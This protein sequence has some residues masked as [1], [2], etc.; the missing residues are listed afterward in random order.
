MKTILSKI[1]QSSLIKEFLLLPER[2]IF[3]TNCALDIALRLYFLSVTKKKKILFVSSNIPKIQEIVSDINLIQ[4][5]FAQFL[6][7][8]DFLPYE[9]RSSSL[10]VLEQRIVVLDRFYSNKSGVYCLSPSSALRNLPKKQKLSSLCAK[11][12]EEISQEALSEKL[13]GLGYGKSYQVYDGG[14]F[15]IRG[16]IFDICIPGEQLGVR[17]EYEYDTISKIRYF[18]LQT[19]LTTAELKQIKILPAREF[20]LFEATPK[21]EKIGEKVKEFGYYQ[22]IENDLAEIF[23]VEAMVEK[24]NVLVFLDDLNLLSAQ[25][26]LAEEA[27]VAM[28][29]VDRPLV[30]SQDIFIKER[31]LNTIL[32]SVYTFS[33][34]YDS[35]KEFL[36]S[37]MQV[38][39]N[40]QGNMEL[41]QVEIKKFFDAGNSIVLQADNKAQIKRI[42]KILKDDYEISYDLGVFSTGFI[43]DDVKLSVFTD[44]QIFNRYISKQN[45]FKGNPTIKKAETLQ[46][47][48]YLVHSDYGIGIYGGLQTNVVDGKTIEC[49]VLYYQG[50]DAIYLPS[51]SLDKVS[52][53]VAAEGIEVKQDKI[54]SKRWQ[55]TKRKVKE[56]IKVVAKDLVDFYA[57]RSQEKGISFLPDN[58][59]QESMENEFLYEPTRDQFEA[60]SQ[61][62]EDMESEK[63]ME[64]LLCG[65]VGYGKT[66]VAVRAAFKAVSSSYQVAVL[67]PTTLLC[68]QLFTVFSQRLA[69]Y[70]VRIKMLSRF[71]KKS[72]QKRTVAELAEGTVDIVIGTHRLLSS[73]IDFARLGLLVI[74]EEH[75]FGVR[76]KEKLRKLKSNIDTLYMSATP[77]PR[78]LNMALSGVKDIS[79]ILSG[80]KYRLPVKTVVSYYQKNLLKHVIQKEVNR[81]GQ[82]FFVHNR[83]E[84]IGEELEKLQKLL[85]NVSMKIAHG[86]MKETELEEI[87]LDFYHNKFSVLVCTSI[88]ENGIDIANANTMIVNRAD[89]FGLSSLYQLRGRV[90]RST[91]RAYCY[92]LLPK[93]SDLHQYKRLQSLSEQGSN[94]YKVAMLDMQIRGVG[95]MVGTGQSGNIAQIGFN[96]YN[97][98]LHDAIINM[99]EK[100]HF[101]VKKI[102]VNLEGEFYIPADYISD[103]ELRLEIY[104]RMLN[105]TSKA[106]FDNLVLELEDRFGAIGINA[107]STI[108]YYTVSVLAKKVGIKKIEYAK[109]RFLLTFAVVP[110]QSKLRDLMS[111]K[112]QVEFDLSQNFQLKVIIGDKQDLAKM[113]EIVTLIDESN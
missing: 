23:P 44:H 93:H 14:E 82:I 11:V 83:V 47:G 42:K 72:E 13:I 59:L 74:D 79:L 25:G 3:G 21:S 29:E 26:E 28:H 10:G 64:R 62:K 15:A 58:E 34:I 61:I 113:V 99:G 108:A 105:F 24:R 91:Q 68:E 101:R 27:D 95:S 52:K 90:G 40:F 38:G 102:D 31:K 30:A 51:Y 85:P 67:S 103:A 92:Y 100:E 104:S 70:P 4:N 49:L 8:F 17:I 12:G 98:L 69:M 54:G 77:I 36:P 87:I 55:N 37:D 63:P 89:L 45:S 75:R 94:G 18:D 41:L 111:S 96:Y 60:I 56:Q 107:L 81:G 1:A 20:T 65:D 97:N 71:V 66:E 109:K 110:E 6:P 53:F 43:L 46:Q 33:N 22:G 80:P 88:I 57:K 106:D 35:E 19:Q 76:A 78:T 32:K 86:Q 7:D 50:G 5:N 16:E 112:Y 9:G 48:E 73:D 2:T 84:S 39:M